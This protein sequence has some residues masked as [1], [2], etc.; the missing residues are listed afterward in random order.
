MLS[1][2]PA[3]ATI[4]AKDLAASRKFYEETLGL[5]VKMETAAGLWFESGGVGFFLYSTP[6]AGMATHTL[7]GFRVDDIEQTV[8]ELK[9]KGL[10]FEEYDLPSLKTEN[11][12]AK[13]PAGRAAWFKD[14]SGNVIGIVQLDK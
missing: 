8:D 9:G 13:N 12:I 6:S 4:P 1:D 14:P 11:G 7:M 2:S 10:T 5:A 3:H